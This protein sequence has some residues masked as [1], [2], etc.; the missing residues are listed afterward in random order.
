MIH[1]GFWIPSLYL[2][3]GAQCLD[4]VYGQ[5]REL[6]V[7]LWLRAP[8]P[9][10]LEWEVLLETGLLPCVTDIIESL[11]CNSSSDYSSCI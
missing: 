9:L 3:G 1:S 11:F 5:I 7:C 10:P 2:L 4:Q 6:S 8:G